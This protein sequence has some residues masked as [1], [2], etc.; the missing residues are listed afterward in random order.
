MTACA[1]GRR[2]CTGGG[3]PPPAPPPT[4]SPASRAGGGELRFELGSRLSCT[5]R[6]PLPP[7][8]S[9]LV[10]RGEGEKLRRPEGLLPR[11]LLVEVYTPSRAV[12]GRGWTS[13]ERG[14]GRATAGAAPDTHL[15]PERKIPRHRMP[16]AG[17][18]GFLAAEASES[19]PPRPRP[20]TT[21]CRG[22]GRCSRPRR[23]RPA[24]PPRESGRRPGW[25]AAGRW[26]VR[27]RRRSCWPRGW[28]R[29][30]RG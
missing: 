19:T 18:L 1:L 30:C 12:C 20:R 11:R 21:G 22:A 8:P 24:P 28:G 4:P 27:R 29:R 14:R 15:P 13:L 5:G 26:A 7:P 23:T 3:P 16:V 9:P 17:D 25:C 10:P 6:A 2:L